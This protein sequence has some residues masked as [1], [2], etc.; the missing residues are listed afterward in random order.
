MR[1]RT[2]SLL[3]AAG[4]FSLLGAVLGLP[5][6]HSASAAPTGVTAGGEPPSAVE[7]F[8]YPDAAKILENKKIKLL[9]GDGHLLLAD[10]GN[11]P[12][13]IKIWTRDGGDFCFLANAGRGYVTLEV[14]KVWALET[15]S[16]PISADLTSRGKTETV[17][18]SKTGPQDGYQS[19]GEGT[20]SD[21]SVLVELRVTG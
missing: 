18:V 11:S 19:V 10:C 3:L 13:Q 4:L 12:Q 16:H 8:D 7:E 2:R 1:S 14:H 6:P 15:A 20:D 5:S 17:N 9:K 21:P